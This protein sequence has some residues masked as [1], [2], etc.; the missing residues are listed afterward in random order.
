MTDSMDCEKIK[1]LLSLFIDNQLDRARRSEVEKHLEICR[2]CSEYYTSL[3]ELQKLA[4]GIEVEGDETY[5]LKQKDAV[6]KRI[7][8]VESARVTPVRTKPKFASVY[9]LVAVAASILLISLV[10]IFESQDIRPGWGLFER[11]AAPTKAIE[12]KVAE[13]P[14]SFQA[15]REETAYGEKGAI[16]TGERRGKMQPP[17]VLREAAEDAGEKA[18]P[19]ID[20]SV[21]VALPVEDKKIEEAEA[22]L[23]PVKK[24]AE[25]P[26]KPLEEAAV[27]S[28][29]PKKS[30]KAEHVK[31]QDTVSAAGGAALQR[32]TV[33]ALV[34]KDVM[35]DVSPPETEKVETSALEPRGID[36][37]AIIRAPEKTAWAT[38]ITPDGLKATEGL[39]DRLFAGMSEQEKGEYVRRRE[40]ADDLQSRFGYLL[41]AHGE[42]IAAKARRPLPEDSVNLVVMEMAVA[43]YRLGKITPVNDELRSMLDNLGSLTGRADSAAALEIQTYISDL[44]S[45]LK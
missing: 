10:S 41:S 35:Y 32:A 6:L 18:A 4:E 30:E 19:S 23:V 22:E 34:D 29:R 1:G 42:E 45:L 14:V 9:K 28:P 24:T 12:P 33:D 37:A 8:E 43:F 13:S 31:R 39:D 5:W 38:G 3:L 2:D 27:P 11:K 16:T 15:A 26:E 25:P 21:P 36:K 40:K 17:E 7:D 20:E 44:E